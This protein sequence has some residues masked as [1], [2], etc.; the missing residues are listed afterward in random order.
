MQPNQIYSYLHRYW[1]N[2]GDLVK[3]VLL[4]ERFIIKQKRISQDVMAAKYDIT[5]DFFGY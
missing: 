3:F 5:L 1:S 2:G 4:D